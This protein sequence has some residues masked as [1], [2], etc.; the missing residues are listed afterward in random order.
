[1]S[2]LNSQSA[3]LHNDDA[4]VAIRDS[5]HRVQAISLI[6]KK[7]YQSDNVGV[8]HMPHYIHELVDYLKDCFD[9]NRKVSFR[10]DVSPLQLDVSQAVP[11]GLIL[12]EAITN[13]IKYAF[14]GNREGIIAIS[15]KQS[16]EGHYT[17]VIADDGKGLPAD[18]DPAQSRSLG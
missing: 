3:Y 13:S 15:F 2:L 18:F 10:I 14:T 8:I 17:L 4:L 1:M 12:N 7:L 6:H 5:Q 11:I 9:T 16:E